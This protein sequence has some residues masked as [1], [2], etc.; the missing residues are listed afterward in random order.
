MVWRVGISST[1]KNKDYKDLKIPK[2][3]PLL[4]ENSVHTDNRGKFVRTFDVEKIKSKT[5]FL[6]KVEQSNLSYNPAIHTLRGMHFQISGPD[7]HKI[8]IVVCGKV[9]INVSNAHLSNRVKTK[10]FRFTINDQSNSSLV[11]PA[12]WATGWLSLEKNTVIEYFM[13]AR[14]EA[15]SYGG[16]KYNDSKAKL[17][18]PN[19]PQVLSKKDQSWNPI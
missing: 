3:E 7:E 15:C 13:T 19:Q 18:W 9:F 4:L 1:Q 11:V 5:N 12:G 8:I 2:E 10:N 14:F 6:M 17:F 16:F